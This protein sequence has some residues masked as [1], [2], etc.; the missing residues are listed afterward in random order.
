MYCRSLKEFSVRMCSR[1]EIV[2]EGGGSLL[3]RWVRSAV[4]LSRVA[5]MFHPLHQV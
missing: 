4:A 3:A 1:C 5:D 2:A